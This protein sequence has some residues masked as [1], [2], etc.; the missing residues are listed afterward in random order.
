VTVPGANVYDKS[1]EIV[2]LQWLLLFVSIAFLVRSMDPN[3]SFDGVIGSLWMIE[4]KSSHTTSIING[5]I[6]LHF[7]LS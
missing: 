3:Y 7:F 5:A 2:L 4:S 1:W 6:Y